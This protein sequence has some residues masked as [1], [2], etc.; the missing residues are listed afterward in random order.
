MPTNAARHSID[1]RFWNPEAPSLSSHMRGKLRSQLCNQVCSELFSSLGG[2]LCSQQCIKAFTQLRARQCSAVGC[3]IN[4][5]NNR[6]LFAPSKLLELGK[7]EGKDSQR[8]H[9]VENELVE[10]SSRWLVLFKVQ[11]DCCSLNP[12]TR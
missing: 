9:H 6:R 4:S 12:C 8:L 3:A 11:A 1:T 10:L 2:Q 7:P 5:G